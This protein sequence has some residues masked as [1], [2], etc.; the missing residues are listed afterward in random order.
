MLETKHI[1]FE[2]AA[3]AERTGKIIEKNKQRIMRELRSIEE[4]ADL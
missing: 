3:K 4:K 2:D 1:T